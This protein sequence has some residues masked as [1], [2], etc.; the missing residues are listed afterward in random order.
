MLKWLWLSGVVIAVDQITKW[1][2]EGMLELYESYSVLPYFN[3]TLARNE[4][5]A[6]S[7]FSDAGG[8]QIG[9]FATLATIV[10][11]YIIYWL[12][13]LKDDEVWTAVGLALVL[14]GAIGNLI[15][16]LMHGYVI[17]FL[18]FYI[19]GVYRFATFNVADIG[20]TMGAA[21][22]IIVSLFMDEPEV[23]GKIKEK[24]KS[25]P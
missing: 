9:F 3:F 12:R 23:K 20:I 14:G 7:L 17:D 24:E 6:F 19:E 15:D 13:K 1:L 4:G 25:L 21:L 11:L 2:S 10:S 22:L 18:D 8:W 5:A 16:R